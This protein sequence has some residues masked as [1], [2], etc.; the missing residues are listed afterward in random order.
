MFSQKIPLNFSY[1]PCFNAT[2]HKFR[3]LNYVI[4]LHA[5]ILRMILKG[6]VFIFSEVHV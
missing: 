3:L 4:L 1:D 6:L 5:T 2:V